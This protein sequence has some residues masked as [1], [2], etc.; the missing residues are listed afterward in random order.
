[1]TC[2]P[3]E[4]I[5]FIGKSNT[6]I[7]VIITHMNNTHLHPWYV[8]YTYSMLRYSFGPIFRLIWV[9]KISGLNNIPP[10]G[11]LIIAFNHQSFFDFLGFIAVC[12]R[13]V[14]F[15]S[16]EKFFSHFFWKHLMR[17][18]GQIKVFRSEHDKHKLHETIHDHL[19]SNKVIG[20]F[21]EGTRASNPTEMLHAFTGV[22]KY[23]IRGQV[24][25]VPVGI[26]GSH[27]IMSRH[28]KFPKF[29]K[30]ILYNI[31]EPIHFVEHYGKVISEK[32]Y[33]DATD[34]VMLQIS[35]LSGKKYLHLGKIERDIKPNV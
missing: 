31:G 32:E 28:D 8:R 34:R 2:A 9:K 6:Y 16:A 12:P 15:L 20:I 21:P 24:P 19:K 33:R 18:S 3:Q 7:S 13:Q 23:A 27:E 4:Y 17:F 29:K 35:R 25:V 26:V 1:M 11:P 22:A 30:I 10:N 14:H 5:P